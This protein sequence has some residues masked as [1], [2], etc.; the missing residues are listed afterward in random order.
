MLRSVLIFAISAMFLGL[1]LGRFAFSP[2]IPELVGSGWL[3]VGAAQTVGAA[4]LV[5]YLVGA[6]LAKPALRLTNERTLCVLSGALVFL[7]YDL[8][9]MPFGVGW[10]WLMRFLAGVGGALL[11]VVATAA[12]G[13]QLAA[14]DRKQFQPMVFVGIG[15]GALFAAVCLPQVLIYG[16]EISIVALML[17][18]GVALA[19]LWWSSGFLRRNIVP[20]PSSDRPMSPIGWSVSLILLAYGCDALGFVMHTVYLPDMLRR[21]Y[22]HTEGQVGLSWAMFGIGACFGPVFVMLFRRFLSVSNALW[23]AF[24]LKALGV[25]LILAA[26]DPLTASLS[27]FIVGMLTPG[28]VILTSGA[29]SAA[30]PPDRYLA[31]WAGGT[32]LFALC[33]MMSGMFIAATSAQ[34]YETALVLSVI[35]LGMGTV[36]AFTSKHLLHQQGSR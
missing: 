2:L 29:L 24:A 6:L 31:L 14:L 32:A 11:M 13:R 7:S 36:L 1:G 3:D 34:G 17:F 10:F 19:A 26:T 28:I 12:A 27:L 20:R 25:A 21:A 15:L 33:Q 4:N 5:G 9:I 30:A 8:L 35:V 23:I 16:I 22:G 18:S